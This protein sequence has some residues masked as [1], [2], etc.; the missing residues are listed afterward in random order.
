MET[1]IQL[2]AW[3]P[4]QD[5]A[6]MRAMAEALGQRS[7]SLESVN[8]AE[9][10]M[11]G[12]DEA[13][14]TGSRVGVF[15]VFEIAV[16]VSALIIQVKQ[17]VDIARIHGRD[18]TKVVLRLLNGGDLDTDGS[19]IILT[20]DSEQVIERKVQAFAEMMAKGADDDRNRF[21]IT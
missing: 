11:P 13:A 6:S 7:D 4:S 1:S 15:E 3:I 9:R 21:T 10:R 17:L 19:C 20:T 2:E 5:S 16:Q 18:A 14:D 12:Q 8:I